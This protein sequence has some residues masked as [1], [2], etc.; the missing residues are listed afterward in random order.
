MATAGS[1]FL[2]EAQRAALDAALRAKSEEGAKAVIKGTASHGA[3][4]AA[5]RRRGLKGSGAA[6]KGGAGGKFT[7]GKAGPDDGSSFVGLVGGSLDRFDPNYDSEEE[8]AV[9][10]QSAH[11][12]RIR[13]E[14]VA[15][16]KEIATACEEYFSSGD[17]QDVANSLDELGAAGSMAHY[18]V[19]RLVTLS[20][21]RRD[22]EREMASVLLSSLY[23]EVISPDQMQKGFWRLAEALDDT[24]LDVP[25]AVDLLALFVARAVVDD[26]LPPSVHAKWCEGAP[27]GSPLAALCSKIDAHLTARHSAE[28]MLRCWGAGA[29]QSHA[30]T[31]ERIG[32]VLAEY[33]DSRDSTEASRCLRQLGVPFFHHELVKQALN[34][35]LEAPQHTPAVVELLGRLT[36]T[37][38][39][40]VSQLAKGFQRVADNIGDTALD[41]PQAPA[42]WAEVL[43]AAASAGLVPRDALPGLVAGEGA[44]AAGAAGGAAA[45]RPASAGGAAANGANGAGVPAFKA[46]AAAALREYFDS[47]D[48]V[49]VAARLAE[50]GEPGM[51]PLF[52]KA[53]VTM[54]MDRRDRER[55][56][57]S[58]LLT[59]LH[60]GTLSD[61]EV[62]AGFT[63]LLAAAD[64]TVLDLPDAVHLLSMFLGRAVVDEVLP[65]AFLASVLPSLPDGGLGVTVVQATG[66]LLSAR[67]AAERLQACWHG[68]GLAGADGL[69][70]VKRQL[71]GAVEEFLTTGASGE[72]A[73]VLRDLAV[74]HYHH[75]LVKEALELGFER[76]APAMERIGDL[77]RDLSARGAL[78]STQLAQGL[79]RVKAR[80]ADEALDAPHAPA[81]F[82]TL[83]A[84]AGREGWLPQEAKTD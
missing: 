65:P 49:E 6:K 41:N 72:V 17:V 71:K 47:A 18:F 66:S 52:V 59:S 46:A 12:S 10:L 44:A 38:E 11:S 20:L 61:S 40:N 29:G 42:R 53:A 74:P 39:V 73:Q 26:I 79:Q 25:D 68:G 50:L 31:K 5:D 75:E 23:A 22:R 2:T 70:G 84:R 57:V 9:V 56:L 64:D 27:A 51:H 36:V 3:T 7:W 69:E 62:A 43:E 30:E 8:R 1:S 35:A 67:H 14:V 55:E 4:H 54:A 16:K 60:P 63:R 77:L 76:A 82:E 34:A 58:A 15:Y 83:L 28:R 45:A 13:E 48:A 32:K 78:S 33:L 21:D 37:N 81:A 80:L 24:L 19:K